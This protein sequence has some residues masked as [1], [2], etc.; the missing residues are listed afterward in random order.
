M[1]PELQELELVLR[2]DVPRPD[3]AYAEQLGR[4]VSEGFPRKRRRLPRRRTLALAGATASFA[5]A[6]GIAAS[7]QGGDERSVN[8]FSG[9]PAPSPQLKLGSTQPGRAIE[10]S[11][12]LTLAAPGDELDS[13]ADRVI[14]ITDR[15]RGFVA[16]SSV[17]S[18]DDAASG[19]T[20]EL[21]IPADSLRP[22]IRD[23]SALA[24]VRS[25][26]QA[27]QDVTR[28]LSAATD[29]LRAARAERRSLL[30]RLE[31]AGTDSQA[32]AIRRRLDLVATEIRG[33]RGQVRDR[34]ER[35]AYAEVD[36]SLVKE[37]GDSGA[38]TGLDGTGDAFHDA[39]GSLAGAFNLTVRALGVALPVALLAILA[40]LTGRTLLRRRREAAL[41]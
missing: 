37:K 9:R 1:T 32:E 29:R 38:A 13:V 34:R 31:R 41:S 10:R 2:S 6:A 21:R 23:L 12:A 3:P 33:L 18:G 27:G 30:R 4:R 25:R 35:V 5:L 16:R 19:G 7:L 40:W 39:L 11:A 22:A 24:H 8:D 26:T 28:E 17:T 36:L 15:Y 14:A 20:F